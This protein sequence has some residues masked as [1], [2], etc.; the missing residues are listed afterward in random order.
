MYSR[1]FK[2]AVVRHLKEG[3]TKAATI[4]TFKVCFNS[5]TAWSKEFEETGDIKGV[6]ELSN[7]R[8]LKID[9]EK[10][11]AFVK[12]NPSMLPKDIAVVFN[13]TDDGIRVAMK[14]NKI[15]RKKN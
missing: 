11:K 2:K 3:N 13:C 4:R 7:R 15:T 9:N 6:F 1:D 5:V 10:L 12:E 14:R 8:P